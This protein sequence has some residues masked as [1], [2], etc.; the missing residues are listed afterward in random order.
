[1]P[2]SLPISKW[3]EIG[4]SGYIYKHFYKH[5]YNHKFAQ[6]IQKREA[7][8]KVKS[9]R[10]VQACCFGLA[11]QLNVYKHC[12]LTYLHLERGRKNPSLSST[13]IIWPS[14]H[15]Y[16]KAGSET[17]HKINHQCCITESR[18]WSCPSTV[19][20]GICFSSS[21]R[22]S[23]LSCVCCLMSDAFKDK[24]QELRVFQ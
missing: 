4:L 8:C 7:W 10:I 13:D 1:M 18:P 12:C 14:W 2:D 17:S 23:A 3:I 6:V 15:L 11:S 9:Q 16:S 21:E 22:V 20:W 5:T 19:T 24:L